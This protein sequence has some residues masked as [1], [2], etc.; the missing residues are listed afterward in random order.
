MRQAISERTPSMR[1]G[2][3]GAM[4]AIVALM[5]F[6][7][8]PASAGGNEFD[9]GFEDQLGRL[10]ATE[11]FQLG[12]AVLTG[13]YHHAAHSYGRHPDDYRPYR[14]HD[15]Y[16]HRGH[17]KHHRWHHWRHHR[18]HGH[19]YDEPCNVEFH[20]RVR[21]NHFKRVM[22]ALSRSEDGQALAEYTLVLAFIALV[23]IIAL[24]AIGVAVSG[25]LSDFASYL[26]GP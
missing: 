10:V 2:G 11:V 17:A 23:C 24:A 15:H 18:D 13:G 22:T 20:E 8:A 16:R 4:V 6:T 19:D 21:R 5:A 1:R 9:D 14:R 12:R 25:V 7:A 26:G 3:E